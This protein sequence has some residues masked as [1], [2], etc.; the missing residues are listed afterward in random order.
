MVSLYCSERSELSND[1]DADIKKRVLEAYKGFKIEGSIHSVEVGPVVMRVN[2]V[3]APDV[4]NERV[5]NK[6]SD[7]A[8]LLKVKSVCVTSNNSVGAMAIDIPCRTRKNVLPG[9]LLDIDH[10]DKVLPIDLGVDVVGMGI[11][12]DLCK[13]PH[14][15]VAGTTGSGKSA[16][17]N[18]IIASLLRNVSETDYSL[19]LID[20]K[21]V[22]LACF[23]DLPNVINKKVLD[24]SEDILQGLD[25]LHREMER[26]YELLANVGVKDIKKFNEKVISGD[27][28]FYSKVGVSDLH[29]MRYIVCIID[30]FADLV[31]NNEK[32]QK[33]E[34][35][36]HVQSL[37][38][39]GRAAGIHLVLATQTPRSDVISGVIKANVPMKVAFRVSNVVD[40]R[41]VLDEA[42]A[43]GLLGSGDMLV[44]YSGWGGLKRLHGV[45]YDDETVIEKMVAFIKSNSIDMQ[46]EMV[47]FDTGTC[48]QSITEIPEGV[49]TAS[50]DGVMELA[51]YIDEK[52]S[53]GGQ[54]VE[55]ARK[56]MSNV[57]CPVTRFKSGWDESAFFELE[58][59]QVV[60]LTNGKD[61]VVKRKWKSEKDYDVYEVVYENR[62]YALRW[63]AGKPSKNQMEKLQYLLD[64]PLSEN[65]IRP[66]AIS[67]SM[68]NGYGYLIF[69]NFVDASKLQEFDSF[70]I[71]SFL[72]M[73]L[74][75]ASSFEELHK[76]GL[77][78]SNYGESDVLVDS[79]DGRVLI[80][81]CE[82]L[83]RM[84]KT[85]VSV[86][87]QGRYLAPELLEG[88][89][90]PD[91][92]TDYYLLACIL[93]SLKSNLDDVD[94]VINFPVDLDN[95]FSKSLSSEMKMNR[96]LR[97]K[98]KEWIDLFNYMRDNY[99]V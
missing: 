69:K 62:R 84:E 20:P 96:E 70:D 12:V 15:L 36:K 46:H 13:A 47:S 81:V 8:R 54:L 85:D 48:R 7:L 3:P 32:E 91:C 67:Y 44:D 77:C 76:N 58:R 94:E 30:E 5:A 64:V 60:C 55:L 24:K 95:V 21:R 40:S 78:F 39:K 41:V 59:N 43:E 35:E 98:D 92:Y 9:N 1:V 61:C 17:I 88:S 93:S 34:F 87:V 90:V 53:A 80:D 42:G 23:K 26:R 25:W 89:H 83:T 99:L 97:M 52:L 66:L 22:E 51:E 49:F 72:S 14:I 4:T 29:R 37:A 50:F 68:A 56:K 71:P 28:S 6:A 18:A 27:K 63:F 11:C 19:M 75:I 2:F 16:F 82:N 45:W 74:Q 79:N 73:C 33:R 31:L 86:A 57:A 10:S 65:F 38:Q